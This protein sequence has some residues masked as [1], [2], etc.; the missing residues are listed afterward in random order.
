M[1]FWEPKKRRKGPAADPFFLYPVRKNAHI[2]AIRTSFAVVFQ[3][4]M[5]TYF[6]SLPVLV[7]CR[8][9]LEAAYITHVGIPWRKGH[10]YSYKTPIATL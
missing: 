1:F 10:M 8:E 5:G 9:S 3:S 2:D 4:A 7:S 6:L